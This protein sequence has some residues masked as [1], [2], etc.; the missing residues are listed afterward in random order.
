MSAIYSF[1]LLRSQ[2]DRRFR[3]ATAI[4]RPGQSPE[5]P[6]HL[7]PSR[8][9]VIIDVLLQSSSNARLRCISSSIRTAHPSWIP[10]KTSTC[11]SS[12]RFLFY[13]FYCPRNESMNS[14]I[15]HNLQDD[16]LIHLEMLRYIL[17]PFRSTPSLS[18][19]SLQR[20]IGILRHR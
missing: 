14:I 11:E 17:F 13:S 10:Y 5:S 2:R 1:L 4:R 19:F 20:Y 7:P 16:R 8:H 15:A 12:S 3:S 6:P 18:S 9:N